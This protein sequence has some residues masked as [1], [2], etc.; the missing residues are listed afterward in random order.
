MQVDCYKSTA[1]RRLELG[2]PIDVTVH[3]ICEPLRL[4]VTHDCCSFPAE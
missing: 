3:V 1:P 4:R 2:F